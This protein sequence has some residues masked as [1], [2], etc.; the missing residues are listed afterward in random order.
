MLQ[1]A[2]SR[3]LSDH[4]D[5]EKTRRRL[6]REELGWSREIWGRLAELGLM[7]VPFAEED[8]G[9]G[10]GPIE[11]MIIAQAFGAHLVAEPYLATLVLCGTALRLSSNATL[12]AQLVPEIA[13]GKLTAA[14]AH[15]EPN[16]RSPDAPR[17]ATKAHRQGETWL[18][19][20][21]K[22]NV[23]HGA[24][25]ERLFVTANTP[26]GTAIFVIDAASNGIERRD[27][28][29]FDG[30]RA[31]EIRFSETAIPDGNLLA[32]GAEADALVEQVLQHGIAFIGAEAVG[33]MRMLLDLTVEHLKTRK[34]FG[35]TL[36]RFQALQHR[37]V[38]MLVAREQ[39]ESISLYAT[40]MTRDA[41][42]I[43]RRKAFAAAKAVIGGSARIVGQSAIQL[44]G[45]IG[46][47]D[48]YRV[49]WGMKRLTMIEM[50]FGDMDHHL[51]ALADLG[52]FVSPAE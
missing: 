13:E 14:F 2:L 51:A 29:T 16:L 22:S 33:L 1:D 9:L 32:L 41:D 28:K 5:F 30:L 20:G 31:A 8:G 44:H 6:Q 11:M 48:E 45:G 24:S 23:L 37:A 25:V 17:R 36:S 35:Q 10:G 39:A 47:T 52:G 7:A 43:E 49:G 38:E 27:Y 46:V 42:P 4:Y 3:L 15:D 26:E 50:M 12:R 18:L 21:T 40:M 34:Q 19:S